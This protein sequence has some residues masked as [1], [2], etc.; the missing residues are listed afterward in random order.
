M[1]YLFVWAVLA[2]NP[3]STFMGWQNLGGFDGKDAYRSA[4]SEL[5]VKQ[6]R[7]IYK[8]NGKEM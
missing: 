4:A 7:C 8:S 3:Y 5:A 6:Y 2:A 1:T